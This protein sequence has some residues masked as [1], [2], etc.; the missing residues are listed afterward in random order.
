MSPM[1]PVVPSLV[2]PLL[3]PPYLLKRSSSSLAPASL[4]ILRDGLVSLS[5]FSRREDPSFYLT[6]CKDLVSFLYIVV[7]LSS[8]SYTGYI[9]FS[10]AIRRTSLLCTAAD[11]LSSAASAGLRF[12]SGAFGSL[13]SCIIDARPSSDESPSD[14]FTDELTFPEVTLSFQCNGF[15]PPRHTIYTSAKNFLVMKLPRTPSFSRSLPR[16]FPSVVRRPRSK[17]D[18]LGKL[19]NPPR[20]GNLQTAPALL[21]ASPVKRCILCSHILDLWRDMEAIQ[22]GPRSVFLVFGPEV[23]FH[24]IGL[25]ESS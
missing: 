2:F 11:D 4:A 17:E 19:D 12:I 5:L 21:V 8:A 13:A 25:D 14:H 16:K 6:R 24:V 7:A 1:Q 20:C 22:S 18:M 3:E 10:G 15:P 9:L 23:R